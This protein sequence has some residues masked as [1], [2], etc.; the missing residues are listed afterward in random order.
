LFWGSEGL[1]FTLKSL[2]NQTNDVNGGLSLRQTWS[3]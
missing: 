3:T 2:H 1:L